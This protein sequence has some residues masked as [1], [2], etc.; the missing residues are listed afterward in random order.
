MSSKRCLLIIFLLW[1]STAIFCQTLAS[2]KTEVY[3]DADWNLR[4]ENHL[5]I[6]FPQ[7]K[8]LQWDLSSDFIRAV[9]FTDNQ[10]QDTHNHTTIGMTYI[11]YT[12]LTLGTE[13]RNIV[14]GDADI[15]PLYPTWSNM[16][17]KRHMQHWAHVNVSGS[18]SV[19]AWKLN[20]AFK[21]LDLTPYLID[22]VDFELKPQADDS[23]Q[24]V[25][26]S[27]N[28]G[29]SVG[30]NVLLHAGL[31]IK[32]SLFADSGAYDF[33]VFELGCNFQTDI[34]NAGMLS[35]DISVT[36][37]DGKDVN[38]Q[39]QNLI[40]SQIRY[41]HNLVSGLSGFITFENNSCMDAELSEVYLISN[42]VRAQLRYTMPW[43][44]QSLSYITSGYKYSPENNANAVFAD[45]EAYLGLGVM[46]RLGF[47]HIP[48]RFNHLQ[49]SLAY[50]FSA[51]N[52]VGLVY[53]HREVIARPGK[54]DYWGLE[55]KLYW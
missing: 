9:G 34:G 48:D 53:H 28:I 42:Y 7:G 2:L 26:S 45:A 27:A 12:R 31:D 10:I 41:K 50:R 35:A 32:E 38:P 21:S 20:G 19:L 13:Y 1:V 25:Y 16:Q 43:D 14:F 51:V 15:L 30:P 17:Y 23:Y 5:D 18:W 36:H 54:T 29:W 4:A 46:T 52:D 37:R 24:D 49:A 11:P 6:S 40:H 3:A 47:S 22:P 44:E 55:T 8:H 39:T 33:N